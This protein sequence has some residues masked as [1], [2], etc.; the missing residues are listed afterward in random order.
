MSVSNIVEVVGKKCLTKKKVEKL[1]QK[2]EKSKKK[3]VKN[4]SSTESTNSS[5][6]NKTNYRNTN[7]RTDLGCNNLVPIPHVEKSKQIFIIKN[8]C[9]NCMST[10]R[11]HCYH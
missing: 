1:T 5:L 7:G 10:L 4:V 6:S 3:A 9:N 2:E 8:A 11:G